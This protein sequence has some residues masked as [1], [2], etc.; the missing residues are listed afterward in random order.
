[1]FYSIHVLTLF[2]SSCIT[3]HPT[4]SHHCWI[5]RSAPPRMPYSC[6][7]T[8]P[9]NFQIRIFPTI[10]LNEKHIHRYLIGQS[11]KLRARST[12]PGNFHMH[13]SHLCVLCRNQL[14]P[15]SHDQVPDEHQNDN[16]PAPVTLSLQLRPLS[17][18]WDRN[19]SYHTKS[20]KTIRIYYVKS[21]KDI[22]YLN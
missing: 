17:K 2:S 13:P 6:P 22:Q 14:R 4:T 18:P 7:C 20:P 21:T 15:P 9:W 12:N 16:L 19:Q 10:I 1:L 11:G 8:G 5:I 3:W